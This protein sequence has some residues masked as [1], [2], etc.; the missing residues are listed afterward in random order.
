MSTKQTKQI[1]KQGK[2]DP[3]IS[4]NNKRRRRRNRTRRGRINPSSSLLVTNTIRHRELWTTLNFSTNSDGTGKKQD[5]DYTSFPPWFAK[6]AKLYEMY[7]LHYIRL[8]VKSPAATTTSGSY[9]LSYNTNYYQKSDS[10]TFAQMAAQQ[11][12]KQTKI[13]QD[14]SVIIPA[15]ALKNFRTNTPTDGSDSWAFNAEIGVLG[16]SVA[17][18]LPVWI[19]YVVTVRNP[20]V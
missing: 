6:V 10:R 8:Y 13:Y 15:S 5:F 17:V 2:V 18:D 14:L 12:A 20:Q 3:K 19:E 9:V 16:N 1:T 11:N 4:N 7:Q